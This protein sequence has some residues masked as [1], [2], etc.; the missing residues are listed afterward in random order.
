MAVA[1]LVR[2]SGASTAQRKAAVN[3][4]V[5]DLELVGAPAA[6]VVRHLAQFAAA[7]DSGTLPSAAARRG[8]W[9]RAAKQMYPYLTIIAAVR[10]L[11]MHSTTCAAERNW[12]LWGNVYTKARN[13]LLA[14]SRAEKLIFIKG[15]QPIQGGQR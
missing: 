12:S 7:K 4:E 14:I 10:L 9:N 5:D 3:Q 8:W 6:T 11:S 2:L 15:N 13:R 1:L